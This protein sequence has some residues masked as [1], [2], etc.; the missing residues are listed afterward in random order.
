MDLLEKFYF[1]HQKENTFQPSERILV[2]FSGGKDSVCLLY[3]LSELKTNFGIEVAACHINHMIRD[4]AQA[5]LDFCRAFCQEHNVPFFPRTVNVPL[6]C[7][8]T[9]KGLEEGARL[10]RYRL[11]QE[12][13][14]ENG[15]SRIATA[16]TASD[17]AETVLFRILRGTGLDGAKGIPAARQNII[18]PLLPFFQEEIVSFLKKRQVSFTQDSSNADT[19]FA[20]NRLRHVVIPEL[21]R[22]NPAVENALLRFGKLSGYHDALCKKIC[23]DLEGREKLSFSH[24][25]LPLSFL[26]RFCE[27]DADFPILYEILSR[28]AKSEKIT[29]DFD[30]FLNILSLLKQPSEGKIIEISNGFSFVIQNKHLCFTK[31]ESP[32]CDIQYKIELDEGKNEI[33][34]LNQTLTLTFSK[35]EKLVNVNKKAL[36]IRLSADKIEGKIVARS[37]QDGDKI[38]MYGMNKSVKKLFC[39]AGIPRVLRP[40]IP[41]IC[42]QSEILWLPFFGLCDKTRQEPASRLMTFSLE[43]E[44]L[45]LIANE[46]AKK[47]SKIIPDKTNV[48]KEILISK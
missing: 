33:P 32:D 18:R 15:Y 21:K 39:D 22:I 29:I 27:D 28:M 9:G 16:H 36:I 20:R 26:A 38:R 23:N 34:F 11:L 7:Q 5:D 48:P 25:S 3:L 10:E 47:Q 45:D 12:V 35:D 44:K 46:M 19:I 2:A 14:V 31:Y 30:R 17:Q 24:T 13:A 1:Y 40:Y 42:D 41:I 43:G 37:F 4:D 8:K 6:F